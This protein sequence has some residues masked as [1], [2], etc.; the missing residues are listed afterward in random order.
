MNPPKAR[1]AAMS[2]ALAGLG[3]VVLL[4]G[5]GP[6]SGS[7][8]AHPAATG[9][10]TGI[11]PTSYRT[12]ASG[13]VA[14]S[15]RRI[16]PHDRGPVEFD[17]T[18]GDTTA[19]LSA[20]VVRHGWEQWL[21]APQLT[22]SGGADPWRVRLRPA[23]DAFG[24]HYIP[25]TVALDQ[26]IAG[27]LCLVRFDTDRPPLA[28]VSVY[29]GG[30][31]CCTTFR[32][33]DPTTRTEQQLDTGNVGAHLGMVGQQP[34]VVTGDDRFSYAF[35]DFADS[36]PPIQL[37]RPAG[38]RLVDRTTDYPTMLSADATKWWHYARTRTYA[39]LGF[40]A[41]WAA[42]EERLGHD[43]QVWQALDQLNA[44]GKL[45]Q[46]GYPPRREQGDGYAPALRA[47]LVQTGY[48][49]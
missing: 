2:A 17:A 24:H 31:H 48:L 42:D 47:F 37:L 45:T 4:G 49:D 39:P 32:L 43:A 27:Y 13:R 23:P 25:A 3:V 12:D 40:L 36:C 33:L 21:N 7:P 38:G 1:T 20:I 46:R 22:M 19:H 34:L 8:A 15:T 26:S 18:L 28:V 5:C 16:R 30:A 11:A 10:P 9:A 6:V 14:C 41:C 29:A 44:A 35:A